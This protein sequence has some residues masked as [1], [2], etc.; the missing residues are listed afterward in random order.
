MS[1]FKTILLCTVC[2]GLGF[3]AASD[4]ETERVQ[5]ESV[6][7][8]S[9]AI[10]A[11]REYQGQTGTAK[12]TITNNTNSLNGENDIEVAELKKYISQLEGRLDSTEVKLSQAMD[13]I[14]LADKILEAK[15]TTGTDFSETNA[16]ELEISQ[17][18]ADDALPKPFSNVLAG[19]T[20]EL[21]KN[22]NQF[23]KEPVDHDWGYNMEMN[24]KDFIAMHTEADKV[25]LASV[26]CKTSSCEIRGFE[27]EDHAWGY[28][29]KDMQ[30]QEWWD[31]TRTNS[32]NSSSK[33]YGQYFYLLA[34]KGA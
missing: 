7:V 31:F 29:L 8:S 33:D 22:F 10:T 24:I 15:D 18:E 11:T 28:L 17:Q 5:Y 3:I 14:D 20:G 25:N 2:F 6:D 27:Q 30:V 26:V 21:A 12:P 32:S 19:A 9:K 23:K 13:D 1:Q 4:L 16:K 34:S